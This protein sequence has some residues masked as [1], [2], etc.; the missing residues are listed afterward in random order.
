MRSRE[1]RDEPADE[2][3]RDDPTVKC[4]LLCGLALPFLP[5][6]PPS[7]GTLLRTG[8]CE[9]NPG[10]HSQAVLRILDSG[11]MVGT[12]ESEGM[13]AS[14]NQPTGWMGPNLLTG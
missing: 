3:L 8:A 14:W 2:N 1:T 9:G 10:E 7:G 11:S 13:L 12:D 5:N 6:N 4:R